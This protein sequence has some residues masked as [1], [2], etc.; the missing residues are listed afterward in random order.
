LIVGVL[1]WVF[2][3]SFRGIAIFVIYNKKRNGCELQLE[4]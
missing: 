1:L 4:Q 2:D 3:G